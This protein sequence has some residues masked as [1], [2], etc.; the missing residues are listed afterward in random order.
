MCAKT[1]AALVRNEHIRIDDM[2]MTIDH[3]AALIAH[4]GLDDD[5]TLGGLCTVAGFLGSLQDALHK[6]PAS[7]KA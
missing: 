1:L 6:Q 5:S 3:A 4:A 2:V 7:S